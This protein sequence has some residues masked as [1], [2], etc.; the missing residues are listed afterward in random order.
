MNNQV[1]MN[2][3]TL[4][5]GKIF[6]KSIDLRT[7]KIFIYVLLMQKIKKLEKMNNDRIILEFQ[8]MKFIKLFI[9]QL[10]VLLR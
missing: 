5:N 3:M 4:V 2:K 1:K 6:E 10:I 8:K 7:N 9:N